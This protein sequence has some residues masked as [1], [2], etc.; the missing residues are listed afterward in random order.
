MGKGARLAL[1]A[2]HLAYC[3]I[4]GVRTVT[5]NFFVDVNC[6]SSPPLMMER[7][8]VVEWDG[9]FNIWPIGVLSSK[10]LLS[11]S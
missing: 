8:S 9:F 6:L 3:V 5:L 11:K 2:S 10:S 7:E 1:S 4:S